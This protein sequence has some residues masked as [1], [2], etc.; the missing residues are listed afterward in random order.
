MGGS[1]RWI[2]WGAVLLLWPAVLIIRTTL[3][4]SWGVDLSSGGAGASFVCGV[5]LLTASRRVPRQR[6]DGRH[7]APR[8]VNAELAA[9]IAE[10]EDRLD[11]Q[12][13]SVVAM[14]RRERRGR[15]RAADDQGREGGRVSA[16]SCKFASAKCPPATASPLLPS[17]WAT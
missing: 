14:A 17:F 16:P 6:R 10:H 15:G 13:D 5:T 4:P 1:V 2:L 9:K 3:D 8:L 12:D 11:A 7:A